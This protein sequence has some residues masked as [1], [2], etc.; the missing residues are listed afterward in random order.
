MQASVVSAQA[1]GPSP[2]FRFETDEFWLNLHHFLYVLGR[3][4]AKTTDSS[5]AAVVGA[6]ADAERGLTNLTEAER[7]LWRE[8]VTAYATGPSLK[9]AVFDDPLPAVT[10]LLSDVDDASTLSGRGI[11]ST[12]VAVLERAAPIYRKAWWPS[13][14]DANRTWQSSMQALVNRYGPMILGFITNAYG[15]QWPAAG[16]AVHLSAYANWAGAY[17]TRGNLLVVSTRDAGTREL[18][19]LE[20]VFHEGMHQWDGQIL[21][22][23]RDQARKIDKAVPVNLSHA[24]IFFTAGE[25]VRRVAPEHVP[26]ADTFGVWQRGMMPLRAALLE[27]WKPYLDGRGT[28]DEALASLVSAAAE[29]RR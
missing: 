27:T 6:P 21:T 28:R 18:D 3:A 19:G 7:K 29:S 9:D 12:L 25:A 15:M 4:E 17:S 14:R 8:A 5:R 10:R 24:M 22:A 2:I 23:L 13:H 16:Y 20:I 1:S 11:E 26:Y